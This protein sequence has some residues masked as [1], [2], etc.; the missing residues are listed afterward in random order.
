[1]KYQVMPS[2]N[3]TVSI[4]ESVKLPTILVISSKNIAVDANHPNRGAEDCYPFPKI[5]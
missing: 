2:E 3:L 1:M 5:N 4:W